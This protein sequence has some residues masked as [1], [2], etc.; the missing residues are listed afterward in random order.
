VVAALV[1]EIHP[2]LVQGLLLV[3]HLLAVPGQP[4]LA[5]GVAG[6]DPDPCLGP[7]VLMGNKQSSGSQWKLSR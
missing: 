1:G 6:V 3:E 4:G 7:L 5:A 2:R